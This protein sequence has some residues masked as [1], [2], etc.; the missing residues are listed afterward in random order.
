M[1]KAAY[2][3]FYLR[4]LVSIFEKVTHRINPVLSVNPLTFEGM[5]I[6][7]GFVMYETIL[8]NKFKNPVNLT[9]NSV[10]DRAII[11][12][13]QVKSHPYTIVIGM[14]IIFYYFRYKLAL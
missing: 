2:G 9:V 10:R 12:L 13:D 6:N 11:Y 8:L 5:D 3:T 4:P 14:R 7:T 1:L